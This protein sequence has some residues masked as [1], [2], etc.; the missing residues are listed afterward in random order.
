LMSRG[1]GLAGAPD[2]RFPFE[3]DILMWCLPF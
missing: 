1:A 2:V 3:D